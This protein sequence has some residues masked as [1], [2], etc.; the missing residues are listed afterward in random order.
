[1]ND[2]GLKAAFR[3]TDVLNTKMHDRYTAEI[4]AKNRGEASEEASRSVQSA[5]EKLLVNGSGFDD[6]ESAATPD[7]SSNHLYYYKTLDTLLD[8]K[9]DSSDIILF[10]AATGIVIRKISGRLESKLKD[11]AILVADFDLSFIIPLLSGHVGGGNQTAIDIASLIPECQAILTTGTDQRNLPS[12][13]VF[14][15]KNDFHIENPDCIAPVSNSLLNEKSIQLFAPARMHEMIQNFPGFSHPSLLYKDS[16]GL[17]G[18]FEQ[19]L[20]GSTSVTGIE[21]SIIMDPLPWEHEE[22][23]NALRIRIRP[24]WIGCGM[25]RGTRKEDI[26]YATR[27]FVRE[28]GLRFTDIA[29]VASFEQKSDEEGL[30][31]FASE[32]GLP[33]LFFSEDEINSLSGDFSESMAGKYFGIKGVAEPC[34]VLASSYKHL[35]LRKHIYGDVT[36]AAAV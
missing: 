22:F 28:H 3:L 16:A 25:N 6:S 32:S 14:A 29:G 12:I 2:P 18:E 31:E 10:F 15:Q 21:S 11:P 17:F 30:L 5:A 9:W 7:K 19:R 36:I 24:F 34:A 23:K 33:L 1:M 27:R 13:D 4:W 20:P 35:F 8:E 26:D